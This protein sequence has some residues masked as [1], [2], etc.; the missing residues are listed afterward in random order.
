MIHK[1]GKRSTSMSEASTKP[2]TPNKMEKPW[3]STSL[4]FSYDSVAL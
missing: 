3:M 4:L 2:T 1:R